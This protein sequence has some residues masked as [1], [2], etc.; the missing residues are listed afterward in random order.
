[1]EVPYL[2]A[3][4]KKAKDEGAAKR[5]SLR[6]TQARLEAEATGRALN[7][8]GDVKV[9]DIERLAIA[10]AKS[11]FGAEHANVQPH[12][13][14]QTNMAVYFAAL[15]PGQAALPGASQL[16]R[17]ERAAGQQADRLVLLGDRLERLQEQRRVAERDERGW[18][19]CR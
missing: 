2:R 11:L 18:R 10:R 13:G 4:L 1:M 19:A 14:S 5:M 9:D 8:P 7:F 16:G 6:A 17:H 12:A 15:D 3:K